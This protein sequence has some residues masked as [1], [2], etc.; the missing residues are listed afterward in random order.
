MIRSLTVS[1]TTPPHV[2]A[3][4]SHHYSLKA[5]VVG[6]QVNLEYS[7]TYT[8]RDT[9]SL[10]EIENEGFTEDDNQ[11]IKAIVGTI[12]EKPLVDLIA[13]TTILPEGQHLEDF[14]DEVHVDWT[15]ADGK[16]VQGIPENVTDWQYLVQEL[17]QA[18]LEQSSQEQPLT[19]RYKR[20]EKDHSTTLITLVVKFA[21]RNAEVNVS[22]SKAA[23]VLHTLNWEQL[24]PVLQAVYAPEYYPEKALETEPTQ[25]G[26]FIDSG[27]GFWY[28][29]GDGV[30]NLRGQ[31][32][33]H[34]LQKQ[35]EQW[36]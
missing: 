14:H 19:I 32:V 33:L 36:L 11:Q 35:F 28:K 20:N 7:I 4:Y 2:P 6:Q 8:D 30:R 1:Y 13:K 23:P 25:T 21:Q 15:T 29:I 18:T 16:R 9:I 26:E 27:D 3:P 31:N 24:R 5:E 10:E 12:W 17:I 22:G 34:K